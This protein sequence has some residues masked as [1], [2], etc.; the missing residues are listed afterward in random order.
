MTLI[1]KKES[2]IRCTREK[3]SNTRIKAQNFLTNITYSGL[4]KND[5]LN[6]SFVVN[7]CN[8]LTYSKLESLFFNQKIQEPKRSVDYL[9]ALG[10]V[11]A[12]GF[13]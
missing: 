12:T 3:N 5:H 4:N 10:K 13:L 11:S 1:R 2:R 8:L 7:V 6:K 9:H